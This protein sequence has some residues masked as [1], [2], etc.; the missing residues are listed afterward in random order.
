MRIAVVRS[1]MDTVQQLMASA[2]EWAPDDADVRVV[3]GVLHNVSQDYDYAV[4]N[5][6]EA[7]R[8]RPHDYSIWNKVK[9][10]FSQRLHIEMRTII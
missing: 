3:L 8:L 2:M 7:V 1:L 4:S 5:F 9:F 10:R 6:S